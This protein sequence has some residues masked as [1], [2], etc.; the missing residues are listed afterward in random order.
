MNTHCTM[1]ELVAAYG[2]EGS[3]TTVA[4]LERCEMCR[5]ELEAIGHRIGALRAL[6]ARR[7]PRDRW[8]I[9]R[10]QLATEQRARRWRTGWWSGLA[11]AAM[12]A[13]AVGAHQ[14]TS[15]AGV[16]QVSAADS[17]APELNQLI[18]QSQ[19]LEAA[20]RDYEP[21]GRVVNGR[22]AS[23]IADLEDRIAVVDAGIA[24][25]PARPESRAQLVNLW[26]DRVNL[27]D[28]LVNVHVTRAGYVGF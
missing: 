24:Q 11:A 8:P 12:V 5:R 15:H 1:D 27:L 22:A 13:V 4:H 3:A 19:Q 9:V 25:T 7:P 21:Q 16:P 14:L 6:P 17:A 20:L 28:A 10:A 26:R 2:R 23:M 18:E